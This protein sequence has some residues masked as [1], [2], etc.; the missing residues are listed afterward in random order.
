[1]KKKTVWLINQ[2]ASTPET[3]IGGRHY[4]L[5]S[6]LARQGY[7]VYLVAAGYTHILRH[8]PQL[9][10]AYETHDADQFKLVWVKTAPYEGAH[11]KNRI[12]NWFS[13]AWK[14]RGLKKHI[15]DAPD[16]IL[17]S[18]L[19]LVGFLG[20]QHLA[21][22]YR[23][24]LVFEVRDIWPLTLTELGNYSERHPFVRFLQWIED[25]AYR[26]SDAVISNLRNSVQHMAGRGMPIEK[27]TW[28]PNG[29]SVD[30]SATHEP[31]NPESGAQLPLGKFIVGYT[32]SLGLANAM[33]DFIEAADILRDETHI[34]FVMVGAGASKEGL[35]ERVRAKQ[36]LNCHILDPIPKSQIP[37]MLGFFDA[38]YIGWKDEGLYRF[39]I[40]ANKIFDYLYAGKP[41]IHAYSGGCDPVSDAA[42]G[43]TVKA[44]DPRAIANGILAL[45]RLSPHELQA[46]GCNGHRYVRAHHDYEK[47]AGKLAHVLFEGK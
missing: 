13:F 17:Y 44:E 16:V 23:A 11:S 36:L 29:L 20:A 39:G 8:P 35:K 22:H 40:A 6:A 28:I 34:A 41:I 30:D 5:A 37:S 24:R 45:S 43:I 42:A 47:L 27:F 7:T 26:T 18:S 3:G 32:G 9:K 12:L 25:R 31:L 14:L 15:P 33:E 1:M 21:R 38:C 46:M 2:Y 10:R 4:S 19:S